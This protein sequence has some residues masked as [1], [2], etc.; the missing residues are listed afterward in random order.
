MFR[1]MSGTNPN[2]ESEPQNNAL[3]KLAWYSSELLG[4]AA[5]VFRSPTNEE[6]SPQRLLQTI[7]RASVVDTI[8][9][10]FQ[11]SYFVTGFSIPIC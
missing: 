6:A 3:L 2:K 5:S 1:C 10:D 8:K 11:R 7:D 4:I 9:Q